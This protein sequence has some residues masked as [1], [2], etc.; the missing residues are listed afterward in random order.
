MPADDLEELADEAFGRPI[1][2]PDATA[3]ANHAGKLAGRLLLVGRE[4]DAERRQRD[5]KAPVGEWQGLGVSLLEG[6]GQTLGGGAFPAAVEQGADVVG[7]RDLSKMPG[8]GKRGVAVA[9][10]HV[11][12]TLSGAEVNRFADAFA[13][14]LQ[15]RADDGVVAGGPGGLLTSLDRRVVGRGRIGSLGGVKHRGF[16]SLRGCRITRAG[17]CD[18]RSF[19][20]GVWGSREENARKLGEDR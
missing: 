7:R 19:A 10:G 16:P 1:C 5:I 12:H 3:R 15:R 20:A 13:D 9:G 18:R 14:D 11:E 2:E 4:H 6:D 8:R 17:D